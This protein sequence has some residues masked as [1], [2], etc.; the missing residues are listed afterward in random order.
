MRL[1]VHVFWGIM[2]LHW[3]YF[4]GMILTYRWAVLGL[5]F[6]GIYC[7]RCWVGYKS[8]FLLSEWTRF[9]Y[10]YTNSFS[11][12][13]FSIKSL[14]WIWL[15][16][17]LSEWHKQHPRKPLRWLINWPFNSSRGF[18]LRIRTARSLIQGYVYL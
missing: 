12:V 10:P 4:N 14:F 13:T 1:Y 9:Y 5:L 17:T 8:I 11:F 6:T 3:I 7:D 2:C 18:K 16:G 15:D